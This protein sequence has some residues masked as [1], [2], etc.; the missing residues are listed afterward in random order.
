MLDA[1]AAIFPE[2]VSVF[3]LLYG[4][5][6]PAVLLDKDLNETIVWSEEGPR[7]GCAA[8]T[9]LFC[10]GIAPLVG[11][12]QA[13]Y[14]DFIFRVLT[15]DI[16]ILIRP[17]ETGL[18]SDWQLLYRRYAA[19]LADL[20]SL[21]LDC[22]GL[23]LNASKCGLLLPEGAPCPTDEVRVL[24]PVGFDFQ[25]DGFRVA[26]SPVGTHAFMEKFVEKKL[27]EAV[28]K[29]QAIKSLGSKSARA[30]HRLL[31]TSGTKL[32]NFLAGTVPP[33]VMRPVLERFD[34]HVD[35]VFF[36]TLAPDLTCSRERQERARSRAA[37]PA[38]HGCG[39]FR[40]V[41]QGKVA[42]LSSVA[43]CM[44]DP[45]FFELRR[46]IRRHVEPALAQLVDAVGGE[47]SKYWT[48]VS[49]VLPATAS[50]FLDGSVFSPANE[51]KVK[52]GKVVLKLLS[53][54]ATD[55]FLALTR[56]DK[57]SET[58][59]KSDVLR[60][61]AHTSAGRIFA[62][63]LC[64]DLPF[65][66]NNEQYLAW[67]RS[68][69]GLPPAST[70]GNHVE[71]KGF[72]YPVQKCLAVHR[73]RSQFLD[74]DG[75]HASAHCPAAHGAL[76]KKH[77]F[78]NRVLARAGKDAG[79]TVRV[80]PDTHSLLLGEFSKSDCRRVFPKYVSAKYRERF[81]EVISAAE[82]VA[83]PTCGLSDEAKRALVQAKVDALPSVRR[84]DV[85]GLR[86]DFSLE[87]ETTGET[88]WGDVTAVHTGAESYQ[89]KE[90][91]SLAARQISAQVSDS[92]LV[93]DPFKS[94]PSPLLIERTSAK[95]S[96]YSRLVLVG[97]KQAAE[98]KRKQAPHF[99]AFAV[100]DYGELAPMAA[101]LLEWLVQQ[102]RLK[103]EQAGKRSDGI[104]VLDR[105]RDFRRKIYAG[106]Q[107]AVAAGC[108]DMLCRAGQA[109]ACVYVCVACT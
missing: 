47:G 36:A 109:W 85:T 73:C 53:R 90:L 31:V 55:N 37:L 5:D 78:I 29:L 59:S 67:T 48:L 34:K 95:I 18:A 40:S 51:F 68:F 104:S 89:D 94:D 22:A 57:V 21:S 6:A 87:N 10:A 101:D 108:G 4:V 98:K 65:V 93:P 50:L 69:L 41:D 60:A 13:R 32:M 30:T 17:P 105:V 70:V 54:I 1:H 75:C 38:P 46:S 33:T 8:G 77:N 52:L 7:Q 84:E 81:D 12:L 45:L 42:W 20:K 83:S 62:T 14:P 19:L 103:E 71:Q 24:F 102:F 76:M 86:V 79:L 97:K 2:G 99:A 43:A 44:S 82:L 66:F 58:L 92:L 61:N 100:S 15:D 74:A 63:P 80:E 16:N 91:K 96:K 72:D 88:W 26:G 49:Q 9:Y 11:K 28:G 39:L 23:V 64:F 35:S 106:V 25:V 56:V 3:N 27:A 107:F